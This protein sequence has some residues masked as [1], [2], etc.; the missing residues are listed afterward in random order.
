MTSRR[1]LRFPPR[2]LPRLAALALVVLAGT[3]A[4]DGAA[5]PVAWSQQPP[6]GLT[7]AQ[8][9]QFVAVTFDDGYGLEDGGQGGINTIVDFMATKTNPAGSNAGT[10]D[11]TPVRTTFYLSSTN[12][13]GA[14]LTAWTKAYKAGHE[15]ADHTINHPNGGT[16]NA[17]GTAPGKFAV[18]K[19]VLE[20][21]GCKDALTRPGG[22]GAAAADVVGFRTPF[23]GYNDATFS[24]LEQLGFAY[25]STFPNCFG[26]AEDGG[27]CSWPH[28]L[29]GDSKDAAVLATKLGAETIKAHPSIMEVPV[30][31]LIVPPDSEAAAYG[32]KAGLRGRV[33][34]KMPYPSLWEPA[35]GKLGGLDWTVLADAKLAPDEMTAILKYT[36]DQHL[37]GNRAPFVFCAH[38][39]MYSYSNPSS[40]P[41]TPSAAVRDARWKALSAFISYAIS[42]PEVRMRPVKD[43]VAWMRNPVALAGGGT[44]AADAGATPDQPEAG[45][46]A[47][48]ASGGEG[49]AG[50]AGA[51]ADA[52]AG[53]VD[54]AA[55]G[56]GGSAAAAGG[57]SGGSGS[58]GK[59]GGGSGGKS[60]TG[61]K[62]GSD[63]GDQPAASGSGGG[64]ALGGAVGA[65]SGGSAL[66]LAAL[67]IVARR[68]RSRAPD[69]REID[70]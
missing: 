56:G 15:A 60:G 67:W 24:A 21:K 19:W 32:F 25:D 46:A 63:E 43:I 69:R 36:L 65:A 52:G 1:P 44:P 17:G 13:T 39:F 33:P 61:G 16:L 31:T 51:P 49:G 34:A 3:R 62:A 58:G 42:K 54:A 14:N 22:V 41:D 64:C 66:L 12:G 47:G 57:A 8:V 70:K 9:P 23:L 2:R 68:R 26:A 27:S 35:T 18:A 6:G 40:N 11:G 59:S 48:G 20:I 38:T 5:A 53:V 45:A 10:F 28:T 7:P 50:G 4:A 55:A 29:D 30:S 37:E